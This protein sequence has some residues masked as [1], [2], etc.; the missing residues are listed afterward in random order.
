MWKRMGLTL[1]VVAALVLGTVAATMASDGGAG[2]AAST[3]TLEAKVAGTDAAEPAAKTFDK[4]VGKTYAEGKALE[5]DEG[6]DEWDDKDEFFEECEILLE[7]DG[8]FFGEELTPELIE[9]I[10]AE[11][12]ALIAHLTALGFEVEVVT[13][14][15]GIREPVFDEEAESDELWEAIDAFYQGLFAAEIAEWSDEDKAEWNAEIDAFVAEMAEQGITV[16][17]AEIAPG[18]YDVVWTEDLEKSLDELWHD[19][20]HDEWDDKDEFFEECEILL[21]EDGFF[22]GEELTPELI[23]EI[24]AETDALIAHLT[25]LGFEVEV[26]TDED[27]IREPVFDEEAESDE[28]WEAI[29]AFYQGLF[30]A[31]I[32]EWSDEDKAEWNAEIDAFVAEMAEQGITVDTAEIAPGVYDVV[33]T[34]DLE[35]SLDELWHDE[36]CD[37]EHEDDESRGA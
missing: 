7:E 16:D 30:A 36:D 22:F 14:E 15:D 17:T 29:D 4:T 11:T 13:D 32:A 35:K 20:G 37:E 19:E 21:E 6:H 18:V 10:N 34:E 1:T 28:L 25:A 3:L 5:D 12:D 27:G 24:N 23:E 33:W 8:F 31:E 26:V 9:E 2:D